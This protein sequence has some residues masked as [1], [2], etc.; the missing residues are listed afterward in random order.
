MCYSHGC[1]QIT[2]YLN[3]R[4]LYRNK[5]T[6]RRLKVKYVTDHYCLQHISS[7]WFL[8][9]TCNILWHLL[10]PRTARFT[11]LMLAILFLVCGRDCRGWDCHLMLNIQSGQKGEIE[12]INNLPFFH[13]GDAYIDSEHNQQIKLS[14]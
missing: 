10:T 5:N 11:I 9:M 3:A 7:F 13:P 12:Y 1:E 8:R 4:L 14:C 6:R 2:L